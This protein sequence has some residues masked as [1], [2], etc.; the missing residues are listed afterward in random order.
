MASANVVEGTFGRAQADVAPFITAAVGDV[1]RPRA[2]L[3]PSRDLGHLPGE[4]GLLVGLGNVAGWARHGVAYVV[5]KER[6]FGRL[7]R[8]QVGFVPFVH[9]GDPS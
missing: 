2:V 9:V 7:F 6:R 5:D 8:S 3:A 1:A 4:S